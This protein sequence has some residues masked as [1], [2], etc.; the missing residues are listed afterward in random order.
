MPGGATRR[1]ALVV[2]FAGLALVATPAR[3]NTSRVIN[4]AFYAGCGS[5]LATLVTPLRGAVWAGYATT[6]DRMGVALGIEL[7]PFDPVGFDVN[8]QAF[9]GLALFETRLVVPL[10]AHRFGR[11]G[12]EGSLG[13]DARAGYAYVMTGSD[14]MAPT[15]AATLRADLRVVGLRLETTVTPGLFEPDVP[16]VPTVVLAVVVRPGE[17]FRWLTG[18]PEDPVVGVLE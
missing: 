1:T 5:G 9:S 8:L 3:A 10:I 14:F 11:G 6:P 2:L 4:C 15:F 16:I 12:E 7:R 18:G 17:F 13:L